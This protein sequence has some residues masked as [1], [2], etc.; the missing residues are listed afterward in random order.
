MPYPNEHACRVL[1]PG[2]FE[3]GSFRRK[4]VTSGVDII[5]GR[6]KGQTTT[7]TQAYRLKTSRFKTAADA[8]KWLKD[9]NVK[10]ASFEAASD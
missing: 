8:R 10:C 1:N 6:L 2:S 4:S 7:R 9:N 5:I 3:A